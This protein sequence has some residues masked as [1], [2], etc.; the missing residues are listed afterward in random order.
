MDDLYSPH[1]GEHI[2]DVDPA[3]W[4]AHAG[5]EPPAY[6]DDESAIWS[7]GQWN[8]VSMGLENAQKAKATELQHAYEEAVVTP[9]SF[10]TAGGDTAQFSAT[11]DT[12]T[13]LQQ[14]LLA[15]TKTKQTPQGFYFKSISGAQLSM[16]YADLEGLAEC[17]GSHGAD[18]WFTLDG[19]LRQVWAQDATE[20]D[21]R[22]IA[23]S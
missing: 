1:T 8:I 14:M 21:V 18:C 12:V 4:M 22:A 19:L 9:Q 6:G 15:F 16:T 20:A 17:I 23:W 3:P 2:A 7:A 10:T 11:P 5:L 13:K